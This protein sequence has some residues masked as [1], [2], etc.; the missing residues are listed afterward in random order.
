MVRYELGADK[1]H[2]CSINKRIC[3]NRFVYSWFFFSTSIYCHKCL[4]SYNNDEVLHW[5][6]IET[7]HLSSIIVTVNCCKLDIFAVFFLNCFVVVWL[8]ISLLLPY[9]CAI[10]TFRLIETTKKKYDRIE[11]LVLR[12]FCFIDVVTKTRKFAETRS[13]NIHKLR[14]FKRGNKRFNKTN[15]R[16]KS[17]KRKKSEYAYNNRK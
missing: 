10:D 12:W 8:F 1:L 15:Q 9:Y 7:Q 5:V 16:N 2:K 3:D 17:K 4:C 14:E 13:K 11:L 6:F